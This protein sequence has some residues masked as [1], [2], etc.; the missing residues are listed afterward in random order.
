MKITLILILVFSDGTPTLHT[1]L[2]MTD[3]QACLGYA[4]AAVVQ[5]TPYPLFEGHA[6]KSWSATCIALKDGAPA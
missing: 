2:P 3:P 4:W 5:Q 6:V 1:E